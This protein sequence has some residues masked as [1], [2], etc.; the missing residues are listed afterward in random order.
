MVKLIL[1]VKLYDNLKIVAISI[2]YTTSKFK[3][4]SFSSILHDYIEALA[5]LLWRPP[6]A[7]YTFARGIAA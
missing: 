4:V 2:Y 1:K 3:R 6:P 5:G 7:T